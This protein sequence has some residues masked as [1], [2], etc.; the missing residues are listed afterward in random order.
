M[1]SGAQ[2]F[3]GGVIFGGFLVLWVGVSGC[4][5]CFLGV[6]GGGGVFS[7]QY[8]VLWVVCL[9]VGVSCGLGVSLVILLWGGF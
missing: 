2:S 7:L 9:L 1:V 3:F 8:G 4:S 5:C 6:P